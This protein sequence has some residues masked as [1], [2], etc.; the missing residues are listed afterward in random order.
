M[1]NTTK[2]SSLM[3]ATSLIMSMSL[4]SSAFASDDADG[5]DKSTVVQKQLVKGVAVTGFNQLLSKPLWDL[6]DIGVPMITTSFAYNPDGSEPHMLT[7]TTSPDTLVATGVDAMFYNML[8]FLPDQKFINVPLRNIPIIL[9]GSGDRATLASVNDST[10]FEASLSYPNY[11]IT[12]ERWLEVESHSKVKCFDD[13][14]SKIKFKFEGLIE[15]GIYTIWG[16]YGHD[17]DGDG[18]QEGIV[19]AALGGVP[20]TIVPDERGNAKAVR[21]LNFC[22]LDKTSGLKVID[23]AYHANG[24]VF[25]ASIDLLLPGFPGLMAAPTHV[26]FPFDAT[27]IN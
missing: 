22:P 15:N 24:D 1:K 8:G 3:V 19:A 18:F 26:A 9:N 4:S 23:V 27:P 14:T 11:P 2:Q 7:E 6:G 10:Q 25:G 21:F 17:A 13:G 16:I 5:F 12:L 20:N